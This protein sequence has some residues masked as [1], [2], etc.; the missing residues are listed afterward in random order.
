[1]LAKYFYESNK[2]KLNRTAIIL[3]ITVSL[4]CIA[5][6]IKQL[7]LGPEIIT[8][9]V[10]ATIFFIEKVKL[11]C[12]II[13]EII[14]LVAL[15]LIWLMLHENQRNRILTFLDPKKDFLGSGYRI[16][17]SKLAVGS[18]GLFCKRFI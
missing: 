11:L 7:D 14:G 6:V 17:Q 1:M 15:P 16:I 2:Y 5:M 10:I 3:L 13:S 9:I 18:G 4:I 12:F 8:F